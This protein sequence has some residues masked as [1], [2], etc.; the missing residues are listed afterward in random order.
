MVV[1]LGDREAVEDKEILP[2]LTIPGEVW[3][4]CMNEKQNARMIRGLVD[5]GEIAI[6]SGA[7]F[8]A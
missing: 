3:A 8:A 5:K 1:G 7:A 2:E 6:T 4:A